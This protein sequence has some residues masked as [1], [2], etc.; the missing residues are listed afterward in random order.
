MA[1]NSTSEEK[2]EATPKKKV[3]PK[4]PEKLTTRAKAE[5]FLE[6]AKKPL[7]SEYYVTEDRMIFTSAIS[8]KQWAKRANVKFFIFKQ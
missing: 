6:E 2:K 5:K 8:A 1:K 3:A 4:A 7:A